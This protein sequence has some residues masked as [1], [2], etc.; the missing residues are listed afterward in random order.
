MSL[1][2]H[3]FFKLFRK[4]W[5]FINVPKCRGLSVKTA[6]FYCEQHSKVLK[7][8]LLLF[9]FLARVRNVP[10]Q[11]KIVQGN[12]VLLCYSIAVFALYALMWPCMALCGLVWPYVAS[13]GLFVKNFTLLPDIF[14]QMC[15]N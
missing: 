15:Q 8:A 2:P 13:Y 1:G 12:N 4:L 5:G 14:Y 9:L 10:N 6:F 11:T 3:S 7:E